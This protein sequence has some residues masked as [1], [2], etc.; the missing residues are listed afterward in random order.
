[1]KDAKKKKR[2]QEEQTDRHKHRG[3]T[4]RQTDRQTANVVSKQITITYIYKKRT[5]I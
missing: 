5:H 1:M 2:V 4:D 3:E